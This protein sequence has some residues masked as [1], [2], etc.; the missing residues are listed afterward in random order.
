[1]SVIKNQ[2]KLSELTFFMVAQ[3]I[4]KAIANFV[5]NEKYIPK[6]KR[7]LYADPAIELAHDLVQNVVSANTFIPQN[8]HEYEKR[9]DYQDEAIL[10]V[11]KLLDLLLFMRDTLSVS[12]DTLKPMIEMLVRENSL[13]RGWRRS[14]KRF[15]DKFDP[16]AT[17]E[18]LT[19]PPDYADDI[20]T[21]IVSHEADG[22]QA[23]Q[24]EQPTQSESSEE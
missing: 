12:L 21:L 7:T 2:R 9:R 17:D 23:Q 13:L 4:R 5:M 3:D 6:R 22:A 24:V 1:M 20:A 15:R 14:D 11:A 16:A 18:P 19:A 10:D 8:L